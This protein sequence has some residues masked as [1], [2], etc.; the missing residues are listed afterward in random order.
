MHYICMNSYFYFF[1]YLYL[2]WII[3]INL[4]WIY[5]FFSSAVSNLFL[6]VHN[7]HISFLFLKSLG[8]FLDILFLCVIIFSF[9]FLMSFNY[10][11][12]FYALF[13]FHKLC[14]LVCFP[15]NSFPTNY[16]SHIPACWIFHNYVLLFYI[17]YKDHVVLI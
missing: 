6:L 1:I 9:K 12:L 14:V 17:V 13:W 2:L 15:L 7:V 4:S 3:S 16:Q 10:I 8:S 11:Q 5:W